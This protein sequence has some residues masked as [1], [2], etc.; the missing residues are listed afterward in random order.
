M[1]LVLFHNDEMNIFHIF[2]KTFFLRFLWKFPISYVYC[3]FVKYKL[4]H[5][6]LGFLLFVIWLLLL[7]CF[8]DL[9]NELRWNIL[10]VYEFIYS[11]YEF[12]NKTWIDW[13]TNMDWSSKYCQMIFYIDNILQWLI[14]AFCFLAKQDYSRV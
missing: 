6:L 14:I 5:I 2:N 1:Q 10:W 11:T 12:I 13:V 9:Y 4:I 7:W 8:E 3:Y